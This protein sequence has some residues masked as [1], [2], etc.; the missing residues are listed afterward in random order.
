MKQ[1]DCRGEPGAAVC[2]K[3][4]LKPGPRLLDGTLRRWGGQTSAS[5]F[6][7]VFRKA[8]G[9]GHAVPPHGCPRGPCIPSGGLPCLRPALPA[10]PAACT[11]P[12]GS[13]GAHHA[14]WVGASRA[15]GIRAE[16][17]PETDVLLLLWYKCL[18]QGII[19][20]GNYAKSIN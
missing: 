7:R 3:A 19:S 17:D 10:L 15:L 14:A 8:A 20:A 18:Q 4:G 12:G 13:P 11:S 16:M 5:A 9:Q 1:S 6:Q 2:G